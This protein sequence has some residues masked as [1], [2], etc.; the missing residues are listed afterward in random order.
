MLTLT[1]SVGHTTHGFKDGNEPAQFAYNGTFFD[2]GYFP[3]I[4]YDQN[5]EI[6]DPRRRRREE[7][8][9]PLEEMAHRGDPVHSRINLFNPFSDWITYKTVVS[10]SG[11]QIAIAPGY[12]QRAWKQDGRNYYEYSMGSTHI[13]DFFAYLSG[14]YTTKK[15]VYSGPNGPVNLEVYY[16]PAHPY[17]VDDMLASS[18]AGLDYYQAHYSPYQFT[19]YRIMEF[20]RYR[21]FAQSFPNTVP[22]S[23]SIGFIS[24]LLKPKDLDLTYF[25]TAHE[26]GHQWWG[27]S[28]DWRTS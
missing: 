21:S 25:V 3:G 9:G 12:Q 20:P 6:D 23:E 17:N 2:S 11:D 1:F 24:R 15:E 8:L 26:L 13:Q 10:T 16:D 18:R 7:H 27:S 5:F 19:Q 22:F 14:R 4:G 28:A